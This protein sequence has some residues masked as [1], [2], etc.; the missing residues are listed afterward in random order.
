MLPISDGIPAR[1]FPIVTVAII[2]A[3]FAVWIF[4]ELPHLDSS[5]AH[6]SF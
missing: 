5:V 4:Y 3:N 1:R 2:L 6:A